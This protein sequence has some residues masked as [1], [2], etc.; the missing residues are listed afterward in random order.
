MTFY[1]SDLKQKIFDIKGKIKNVKNV[2]FYD[3]FER[4]S[5]NNITKTNK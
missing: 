5:L 1:K 4:A 2:R 3:E